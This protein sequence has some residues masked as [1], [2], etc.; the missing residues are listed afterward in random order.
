MLRRLPLLGLQTGTSLA[1]VFGIIFFCHR[2]VQVNQTSVALM[3]LLA[4][5]AVSTVWGFAVSAIMSV[6]AMLAFNYYFLPPVGTFTIADPQNWVALF[7]F[8]ATSLTAS[9]LSGRLRREASEAQQRRNEVE[10]LYTFSQ[11]LLVSANVMTLLNAIPN[12]IVEIFHVGAA[13]IFMEYKQKFYHSGGAIHFREEDLKQT[14]AREEPLID[15]ERGLCFFPVRLGM[16]P[17][18][19]L[20][21][22]GGVLS[23]QTLEALGSLVAVSLERARAMEE[24][25]KT[26]AAREGERLK[27]A[28]LDS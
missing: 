22:S 6:A 12:Y 14:T 3:L 20:A 1:I 24:L 5:L 15:A 16:R 28:L 26:E 13:A 7:T 9:Q 18:G 11:Q 2:V 8:L 17:I 10:R 25:S 27:S 19:S 4:I 23:R 21:I